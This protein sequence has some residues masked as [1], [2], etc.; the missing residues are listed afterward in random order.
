M[1]RLKIEN[2]LSSDSKKLS[3]TMTFKFDVPRTTQTN[4]YDVICNA[5]DIES[6]VSNAASERNLINDT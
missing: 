4:I 2:L 1:E 5:Y 3:Y 6:T